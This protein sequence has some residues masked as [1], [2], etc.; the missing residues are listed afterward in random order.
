[1]NE[2]DIRL[3]GFMTPKPAGRSPTRRASE[4]FVVDQGSTH[5]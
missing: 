2:S 5:R 1:M 4:L 3:A